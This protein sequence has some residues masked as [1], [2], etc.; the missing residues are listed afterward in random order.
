MSFGLLE[1]FSDKNAVLYFSLFGLSV[2][3]NTE[4][5][6]M[7]PFHLKTQLKTRIPLLIWKPG[8]LL[9]MVHGFLF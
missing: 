7:L 4:Q 2:E 6:S 9:S 8:V 5:F 1:A 3:N